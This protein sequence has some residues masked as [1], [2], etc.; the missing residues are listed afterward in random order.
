MFGLSCAQWCELRGSF[1]EM[2]LRW[3][4]NGG[5]LL[6]NR[7]QLPVWAGS[8]KDH[9]AY[10]CTSV[11]SSSCGLSM[12]RT[13]PF[14][15]TWK[16]KWRDRLN[17]LGRSATGML[18]QKH[19]RL[20]SAYLGACVFIF[21]HNQ[22]DQYLNN[23]STAAAP[24]KEQYI[25]TYTIPCLMISSQCLRKNYLFFNQKGSCNQTLDIVQLIKVN[26]CFNIQIKITFREKIRCNKTTTRILTE[27]RHKWQFSFL[28]IFSIL[29]GLVFATRHNFYLFLIIWCVSVCVCV[30]V[31]PFV[32]LTA[33]TAL[34]LRSDFPPSCWFHSV[35][36]TIKALFIFMLFYHC[37]VTT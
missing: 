13:M 29:M 28:F 31:C 35:T 6:I 11:L 22:S 15:H 19:V 24:D 20:C 27:T 32:G 2:L 26:Q 18:L 21:E 30:C 37:C 10:Y 36:A 33:S 16:G 23:N 17:K 8:P 14:N 4:K 25:R 34:A 12:W 9:V 7:D 5:V 1:D 3:W